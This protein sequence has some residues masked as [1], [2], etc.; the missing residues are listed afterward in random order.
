ML[1]KFYGTRGSIPICEKEFQTYG[2]NTPCVMVKSNNVIGILDAGTGIRNLGIDILNCYEKECDNIHILFSHFHWDHIQGFPF[3]QP[4][5][6]PDRKIII[7][8]IGQNDKFHKFGKILENQ[9]REEYFPIPMQQMGA[10]IKYEQIDYE[11]FLGEDYKVKS[12]RH[13]H[14]GGAYTYRIESEGKSVVYATD[15]E[16]ANGIDE[17]V[18]NISQDADL[19][20][21]DSHYTDEELKSKKGWGHSSWEQAVEV[22]QRANVKRLI[23]THHNPD[24]DDNFLSQIEKESMKKFPN[25]Q[26]ARDN[27][28]IEL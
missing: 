13:I 9:M 20:I 28:E 25:V 6:D 4:A 17:R 12:S 19:L 8:A 26:L 2:G 5:Y 23:L 24:H 16:H 14:P 21:H 3:F 11:D 10:N 18:V 1:I 22:A 7:N 27:M 15:V